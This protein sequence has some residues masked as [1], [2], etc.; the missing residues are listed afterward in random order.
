MYQFNYHQC[1]DEDR[2]TCIVPARWLEKPL[3]TMG[4]AIVYTDNNQKKML[5]GRVFE[6]FELELDGLVSTVS[7]ETYYLKENADQQMPPTRDNYIDKPVKIHYRAADNHEAETDFSMEV[8]LLNHFFG[9]WNAESSWGNY[10]FDYADLMNM[11]PMSSEFIFEFGIGDTPADILPGIF[12]RLSYNEAKCAF[13]MLY[14]DCQRFRL[15]YIDDTI[16]A[17]STSFEG[18]KLLFGNA[19]VNQDKMLISALVGR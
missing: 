19:A 12:E 3:P 1:S 9:A 13:L 4:G 2:T 7:L 5:A 6:F 11:L 16:N 18:A 8:V 14:S 15:A 10:F 17:F